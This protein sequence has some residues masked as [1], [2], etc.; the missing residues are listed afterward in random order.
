[1]IKF[2][3][4]ADGPIIAAE[5]DIL[6]PIGNASYSGADTLVIPV[7]RLSPDFFKLSTGLAG[8]ILQKCTN[9]QMKVAVVGDISQ[10]TAKSGPLRDFIYESNKHGQ[11]RF[12]ATE[13]EL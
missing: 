5:S 7:G 10:F 1:M 12:I 3:L 13:A 9:Y 8:A 4:P 2:T 11:V 6:D